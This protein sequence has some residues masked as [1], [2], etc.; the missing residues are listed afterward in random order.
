MKLRFMNNLYRKDYS[1]LEIIEGRG[2]KIKKN[3]MRK[4]SCIY[5][6]FINFKYRFNDVLA[7]CCS[8]LHAIQFNS[9]DSIRNSRRK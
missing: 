6:V 1:G 3:I 9:L 4:N 7:T 5:T 2:R 8:P